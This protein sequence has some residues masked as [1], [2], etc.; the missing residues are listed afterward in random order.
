MSDRRAKQ[1]LKNKTFGRSLVDQAF[2]DVISVS[3]AMKFLSRSDRRELSRGAFAH[4]TLSKT[5]RLSRQRPHDF[6]GNTREY[7]ELKN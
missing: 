1:G 2:L 5:L 6:L 7:L 3:V 4:G